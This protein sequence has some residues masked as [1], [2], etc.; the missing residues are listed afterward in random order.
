MDLAGSG[1]LVLTDLRVTPAGLKIGQEVDGRLFVRDSAERLV[2][3]MRKSAGEEMEVGLAEGNYSVVRERG[4]GRWLAKVKV[5][6][7]GR[8]MVAGGDFMS[9]AREPTAR[10]GGGGDGAEVR[11]F[12][13]G[14]VP[15]LSTNDLVAPRVSNALSVGIPATRA[16]SVHG[17]ALGA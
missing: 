6:S 14:L 8:A 4:D 17:F 3:E 16:A 11:F 9:I 13:V 15:F 7:G 2:L 1:D 10:R 5:S 12:N